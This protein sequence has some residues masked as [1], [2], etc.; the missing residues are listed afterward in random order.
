MSTN[1]T[2]S[3][4]DADPTLGLTNPDE[5]RVP[6]VDELRQYRILC[7]ISIQQ[8]AE[9]IGVARNTLWRWEQGDGS[10]GPKEIKALLELYRNHS[11]GQTQLGT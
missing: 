1:S 10:P 8:A 2:D 5:F 3:E 9:E 7:D 11:E 4:P 6:S